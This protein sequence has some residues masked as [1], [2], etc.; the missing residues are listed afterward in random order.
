M[1]SINLITESESSSKIR[2]WA[3]IYD[4]VAFVF[5]II[6]ASGG[7]ALGYNAIYMIGGGAIMLWAVTIFGFYTAWLCHSLW[8]KDYVDLIIIRPFR[9]DIA[10]FMIPFVGLSIGTLPFCTY[11]AA[12][13]AI[14]PLLLTLYPWTSLFFCFGGFLLIVA[15]FVIRLFRAR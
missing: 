7:T 12:E 6:A 3:A 11:M 15:T 1:D 8:G 4:P 10:T 13:R 2:A 5:L 9:R 14:S